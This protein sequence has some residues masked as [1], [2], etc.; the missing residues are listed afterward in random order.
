MHSKPIAMK[1]VCFSV[2]VFVVV[3]GLSG[4]IAL[5][6]PTM[7]GSVTM[8]TIS[9]TLDRDLEPVSISGAAVIDFVGLP[10]DEL[11]VYV[12]INGAFRQIPAQIDEV[13]P[14]GSYVVS[15]DGLLDDND[16]IVFM[17][18][19][20]G[21]KVLGYPVDNRIIRDRIYEIKVSDPTKPTK[22]G[23]AYLVHS[24]VLTPT[25]SSDYVDFDMTLRRIN[26]ANYSLG[27]GT[28][29]PGFEYLAL[30]DSDVDILDRTKFRLFCENPLICPVTEEDL[31]LVFDDLVKDG[32]VR[33][34]LRGGLAYGSMVDWTVRHTLPPFLAGDLCLST[35]FNAAVSGATYYN[36]VVPNGVIVDGI[37]DPVV[38]KPLSP[39]WQLST[40]AGT[41]IQV[42]NSDD[43]GGTQF[44]H[45]IDNSE[46]VEADTGD[47][48]RYGETGLY[49]ANPNLSFMYHFA[50]YFLS[51]FHNNVGEAYATYFWHPLSVTTRPL[52]FTPDDVRL[53]DPEVG[54]LNIEFSPDMQYASWIEIIA[55]KPLEPT[56]AWLCGVDPETGDLIPS[57][58]RGY[59][60]TKIKNLGWVAGSPQWG[61]DSSGPFVIVINGVNQML[62]ARPK[63]PTMATV[64]TLPT[65]PNRTRFYPY[66]ARLPDRNQSYVAYL[67]K[68]DQKDYQAWYVD[69]AN[70]EVEHQVTFGPPGWYPPM[71][72]F[73]LAVN[74]HR[75][76]DGKPI[77]IFGYSNTESEKVQIKQ[78]D[79]S[80]PLHP[81]IAITD[82]EY[83]HIDDF[84][85]IIFGDGYLI[86]GINNEPIGKLYKCPPASKIYEPVQT[87]IPGPMDLVMPTSAL[88]FEVFTWEE[89]AFA[90][91]HVRDDSSD[92]LDPKQPG[93][94]WLTS[95]LNDSVLRRISSPGTMV[96]ADPEFYIGTSRVWVY[97]SAKPVDGSGC[98]ELHRAATGLVANT[99]D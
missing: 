50:I 88:G 51:G 93:E 68:D 98:W 38:S 3:V 1:N 45:Y 95:L 79:V 6:N 43:I 12:H 18:K 49:I 63:S 80:L 26:A 78:F 99:G 74:I 67:Q 70:P 58:G 4:S 40:D 53:G 71:S 96:R 21:N 82:D 13:T 90:S 2:I 81:P 22:R 54:Y 46:V 27:L 47:Q 30:G 64:T 9:K 56:P 48:Q 69:L 34:I 39:W 20:L 94:I 35:D 42:T 17:A 62:M 91:F 76:F 66:P 75:W 7:A 5:T 87:I 65:P 89:K 57:D 84:P 16:E 73:P 44:N 25:F 41:L 36:S 52:G 61:E 33:V 19:D 85:A 32:P 29:H 37:A 55:D 83:D 8:L 14:G 59:L 24:S 60:I 23:W 11:F 92:V 28:T 86:G 77:F 31:P 97:Y 72:T 15:E 10:V